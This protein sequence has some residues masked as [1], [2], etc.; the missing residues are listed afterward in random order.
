MSSSPS[1]ETIEEGKKHPEEPIPDGTNTTIITDNCDNLVNNNNEKKEEAVKQEES[2]E[3]NSNTPTNPAV[4]NTAIVPA[5]T[6]PAI[7][8]TIK[9]EEKRPKIGKLEQMK[10]DREKKKAEAK[11]K[12]EK[13]KLEREKAKK[14]NKRLIKRGPK[15]SEMQNRNYRCSY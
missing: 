8:T 14:A 6:E 9:Q 4:N 3:N 1:S 5:T 13:E 12:R 11:A 15:S 7:S 2:I 10:L